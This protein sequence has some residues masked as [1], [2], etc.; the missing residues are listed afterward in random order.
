MPPEKNNVIVP[1]G[2]V[3]LEGS[4]R[5]ASS[6]AKLVGQVD[7]NENFTVTILLRRRKDGPPLPDLDYF[8][9]TSPKMRKRLSADEF[10]EKYGAHPDDIAAVVKFAEGQ[11]LAVTGTHAGRRAVVVAGTG[12]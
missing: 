4:E 10:T 1:D 12:T 5:R 9:R 3:R 8:T 11:G 2:Y 7:D 6:K